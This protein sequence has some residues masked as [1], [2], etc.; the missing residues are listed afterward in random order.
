M[1]LLLDTHVLIWALAEP[2]KLSAKARAALV[3]AD[4]EIFV[5]AATGWSLRSSNL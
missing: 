4:N 2:D 3:Q 1:R 5:S